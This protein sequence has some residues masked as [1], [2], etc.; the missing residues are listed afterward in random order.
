MKHL[1]SM[2]TILIA[3]MSCKKELK[4]QPQGSEKAIAIYNQA[5]Q[6]NFEGDKI[7]DIIANATNAYVLIDPFENNVH[8]NISAIKAGGNE[9]GGY[10]SI[11][12]TE[13]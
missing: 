9:V 11:G 13:D 10:I 12:T 4:T 2:L 7:Q 6:E 8:L 5:Y 3:F 1:I